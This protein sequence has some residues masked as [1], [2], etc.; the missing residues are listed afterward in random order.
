M[1]FCFAI[2]W[3]PKTWTD[4]YH[5]HSSSW[6]MHSKSVPLLL[7]KTLCSGILLYWK[8]IH[9][10]YHKS[11]SVFFVCGNFNGQQN[12][13]GQ[14][15]TRNRESYRPGAPA[16]TCSVLRVGG[17]VARV[18][19]SCLC[20]C[21]CRCCRCR[22]RRCC[23]YRLII[24]ASV[25]GDEGDLLWTGR[26][27]PWSWLRAGFWLWPE[28]GSKKSTVTDRESNKAHK[29]ATANQGVKENNDTAYRL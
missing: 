17:G 7:T 14:W 23:C 9:L 5:T 28:G 8:L 24:T 11:S 26:P 4:K 27:R 29:Q 10:T 19:S 20:C 3:R 12:V 16:M 21:C 13:R 15:K 18:S 2:I 1:Y 6:H 22:R 25:A